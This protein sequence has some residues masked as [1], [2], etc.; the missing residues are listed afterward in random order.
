MNKPARQQFPDSGPNERTGTANRPRRAAVVPPP[1][2]PKEILA[3]ADKIRVESERAAEERQAKHNLAQEK[4]FAQIEKSIAEGNQ[5]AAERDKERTKT[6]VI[7]IGVAT[8]ILGGLI[9]FRGS[10]PAPAPSPVTIQYLSPQSA[11][12]PAAPVP[13]P[14]PAEPTNQN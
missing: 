7:T 3:Q 6:I 12:P 13:A 1:A 14:S 2:S 11:Q 9:E 4:R 8:A 10:T 5:K